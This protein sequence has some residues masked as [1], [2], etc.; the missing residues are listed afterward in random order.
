MKA[1]RSMAAGAVLAASVLLTGGCGSSSPL[2]PAAA[3]AGLE[4]GGGVDDQPSLPPACDLVDPTALAPI[5]GTEHPQDGA[6]TVTK[7]DTSQGSV[8]SC[9]VSW[10]ASN[11]TPKQFLVEVLHTDNLQYTSPIGEKRAIPGIGEEAFEAGDN[12]FAREGTVVVHVVNV[13]ETDSVSDRVLADTV[14]RLPGQ[15]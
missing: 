2:T 9:E 3:D 8:S 13:Q 6:F 10:G 7:K 4:Q 1:C 15:G 5:L 11:W 14:S 12:W